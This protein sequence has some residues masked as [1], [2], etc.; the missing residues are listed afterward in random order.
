VDEYGDALAPA[1]A[2]HLGPLAESTLDVVPAAGVE[3]FRKLP[4]VL[5][6]PELAPGRREGL[7]GA[8]LL[9]TVALPVRAEFRLGRD[10]DG[11]DF[12][13]RVLAPD[14]DQVADTPLRKLA[15]DRRHPGAAGPAVGAGRAQQDAGLA[16]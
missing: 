15:L 16:D 1:D 12:A 3:E 2:L 7:D 14:D 9:P 13:R 6:P 4:V 8:A 5:R 11:N 10:P